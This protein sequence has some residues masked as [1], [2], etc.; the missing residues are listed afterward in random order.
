MHDKNDVKNV[1]HPNIIFG[2]YKDSGTFTKKALLSQDILKYCINGKYK[3]D[4]IESFRLW[5]LAK[6]LLE[7]NLEFI[8][9]FKELSTRNYTT[10]N[11]IEYILRRIKHNVEKLVDVGLIMQV[12]TEKETKG[13]GTV[14]IFQFT[15]LGWVMAWVVESMNPYR[16]E[17]A[18]NQIYEIFQ[19]HY[20]KEPSSSIDIFCSIYY[21]K[22]KERGIFGDLIEHYKKVVGVPLPML[23]RH[24]FS[25]HLMLIPKYNIDS[26]IDFQ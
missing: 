23:G 12:R 4:D 18:L 26:N 20:R 5:N 19:N 1:Q 10:S 21:R 25:Y 9:H 11:K 22:C 6:W 14:P 17:H 2:K 15:T 8:N 3:E 7:V 24:G 16:R 13:T